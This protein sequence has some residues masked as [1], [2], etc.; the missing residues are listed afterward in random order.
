VSTHFEAQAFVVGKTDDVFKLHGLILHAELARPASQWSYEQLR[1]HRDDRAAI[2]Y[3]S[4]KL[5]V[6]PQLDVVLGQDDPLINDL[7]LCVFL[8]RGTEDEWSALCY[9][10]GELLAESRESQ[11]PLDCF[12]QCCVGY[13]LDLQRCG[14][15]RAVL[16]IGPSEQQHIDG[17]FA[18]CQ[19]TLWPD[20]SRHDAPR[21]PIERN[22]AQDRDERVRIEA[23]LRAR[24]E[25]VRGAEHVNQGPAP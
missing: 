19:V 13:G 6:R 3:R 11:G 17:P 5:Q 1:T 22:P 7:D 24:A 2:A 14:R 10:R 21:L 20:L 23:Q 8:E 16:E 4:A 15:L 9:Q 25:I 12:K 18:E